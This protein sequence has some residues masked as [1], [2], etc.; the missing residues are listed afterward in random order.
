M[1]CNGRKENRMKK[2]RIFAIMM[3]VVMGIGMLAGCG[4]TA[5]EGGTEKTDENP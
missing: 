1:N 2:R 3:S 5:A 4:E